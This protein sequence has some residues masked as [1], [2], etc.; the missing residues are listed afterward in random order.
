M[1]SSHLSIIN[2]DF[3]KVVFSECESHLRQAFDDESDQ[4]PEYDEYKMCT[5]TLATTILLFDES[6]YLDEATLKYY[7]RLLK[8]NLRNQEHIPGCSDDSGGMSDSNTLP[9][10][11]L[12]YKLPFLAILIWYTLL[13]EMKFIFG[14][15]NYKLAKIE[16]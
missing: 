14:D 11:P 6:N 5:K 9:H 10:P 4:G 13:F 2:E 16:S 8:V 1:K 15:I 7:L 3:I 12:L